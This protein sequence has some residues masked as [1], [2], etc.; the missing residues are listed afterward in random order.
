MRELLPEDVIPLIEKSA[1]ALVVKKAIEAAPSADFEEKGGRSLILPYNARFPYGL[2]DFSLGEKPV[3]AKLFGFTAELLRVPDFLENFMDAGMKELE[4]AG[5]GQGNIAARLERAGRFRY[6]AMA[7]YFAAKTSVKKTALNL[8][9]KYPFGVS[10]TYIEKTAALADAAM[11]SLTRVPRY[12][13]MAAGLAL[14][15]ALFAGY[16]N[17]LVRSTLTRAIPGAIPVMALDL[18]LAAMACV[19]PVILSQLASKGAVRKALDKALPAEKTR[20]LTPKP[21]KTV[22]WSAGITLLLFITVI[23]LSALR[24]AEL[25]PL[26]YAQIKAR[27]T[28]QL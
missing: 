28:A 4:R 18:A 24:S 15:A 6:F 19:I 7:S 27:L 1:S 13:G 22:Y 3:R 17:D 20:G 9:G 25:F 8:R 16:F 10:N 2:I 23:E 26:W 11:R 12:T 14:N 5:A 21:G